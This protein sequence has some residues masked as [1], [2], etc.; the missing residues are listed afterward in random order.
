MRKSNKVPEN[1]RFTSLSADVGTASQGSFAVINLGSCER[2]ADFFRMDDRGRQA[3]MVSVPIWAEA[4]APLGVGRLRDISVSGAKLATDLELEVGESVD[5]ELPNIGRRR[6]KIVWAK[7][8]L[9]GFQFE[10]PIDPAQ[11]RKKITGFYRAA[12]L[13]VEPEKKRIL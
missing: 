1:L 12:E 2:F 8:N 9:I 5:L 7:L 6:A 11:I 4:P 10:K 13:P 3:M